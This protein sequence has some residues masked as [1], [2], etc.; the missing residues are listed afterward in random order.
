MFGQ[1]GAAALD[2]GEYGVG[3][4]AWEK[5]EGLGQAEGQDGDQGHDQGDEL[6]VSHGSVLE[7]LVDGHEGR[8]RPAVVHNV[9]VLRG[10]AGGPVFLAVRGR[11]ADPAPSDL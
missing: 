9:P 7:R 6:G 2:L 3:A 11:Q 8:G 4:Q 5:P 10:A 1:A